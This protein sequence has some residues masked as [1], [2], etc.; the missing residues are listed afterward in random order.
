MGKTF[1]TKTAILTSLETHKRTLTDI[2][3]QLS[4]SPSTVKQHLEELRMMGMVQF[5]EG[6]HLH[7]FK[8]YEAVPGARFQNNREQAQAAMVG[9]I[10]QLARPM[11]V[12][13]R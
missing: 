5:V 7:R 3:K 6:T 2:S 8:Y 1:E 4:L 12:S 10:R 11:T 9:R 13:W